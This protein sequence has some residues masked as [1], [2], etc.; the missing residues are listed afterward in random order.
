M[1]I[2]FGTDG[3]RGLIARDYTFANLKLAALAAAKYF[4]SHPNFKNGVCVGYD[5]RFMSQQFATFVAE[6]YSSLG[7]KVMLSDDFVPTPAVSLFVRDKAL[8]GGVMITASHN[9]PLYN[10]FKV[11]ADYGGSAHPEIIAEIEAA[12]PDADANYKIVRNDDFIEMT[13]IKGYYQDYLSERLDLELIKQ[14]G[15]KIGHNAMYGAGQ[16]VV[17]A[18]LGEDAIVEYHCTLDPTFQGINPEPIPRYTE[19]FKAFSIEQK[20]DVGILNDGDA[21]RIGMTDENG[22]FVDSHKLFALILKYLVEVKGLRGEVAKTYAL[23]EVINKLCEKHKLVLHKLPIGFKHVGKLMTTND[24]LMGGEES[25]GIGITSHLAER[26]GVFIGLLVLEIM[27]RR[28]KKLSA[29][30]QELYDEFGFFY[31]D[32]NDAHLTEAEKQLAMSRASK[33]EFKEIDGMKVLRFENLDGYKYFFEGGWVLIRPS[34]TEPVLRLY[35]E[36]DSK[37]KVE[38]ALRFAASLAK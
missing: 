14:S 2:K 25:G 7:I 26:D 17:K 3:W 22:E 34:G 38:K 29:L 10:G 15:F 31:Y 9:P 36:A 30:V 18:L 35:S 1:E 28:G 19:D 21:D 11:K 33:G 37:E 6:I 5:T 23:T 20:L 32:R 13:D 12:L 24:I 27:A 16:G 4:Q 8:A